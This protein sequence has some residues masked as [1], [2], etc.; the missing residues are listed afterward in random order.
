MPTTNPVPSQDPSDLL[1]NAG[2]LD[3]V[4]NGTAN[5]F[6]DRLGVA[7]RT[8]AGMN[9]DFDAQLA[10]AE[11]D[12]NVYRADAAASAAEALGYLQ[13]IRATSYG[14]YAS[15]P[16]TD[17]L[18]NPPTIGDEYFNTTA[19]LLK[20]WNGATWQASDINT[21]NLAAS[22]GSSLVGYLPAGTGAVTTTVQDRLR[23]ELRTSGYAS[24]GNAL[25]AA[26]TAGALLV[27]D[28]PVTVSANI[29]TGVPLLVVPGGQIT[30]ATGV[31]LNINGSFQAGIFRCFVCQ[32]TGK[33]AFGGSAT[34]F[35]CPEWWGAVADGSTDCRSAFTA[36]CGCGITTVQLQQGTYWFTHTASAWSSTVVVANNIIMR[37]QGK[38][39]TILADGQA[40]SS[41]YGD[42][43]FLNDDVSAEFND[44]TFQGPLTKPTTGSSNPDS[45]GLTWA[46]NYNYRVVRLNNCSVTGWFNSFLVKTSSY[47]TGYFLLEIKNCEFQSYQACVSV[48]AADDIDGHVHV[49]DSI[50]WEGSVPPTDPGFPFAHPVYIHPHI[51][52]HFER[53]RFVKWYGNKYA[54]HHYSQGGKSSIYAKYARYIDCRFEADNGG[55][56]VYGIEQSDKIKSE[57]I[58]C[59]FGPN[60]TRVVLAKPNGVVISDSEFLGAIESGVSGGDLTIDNCKIKQYALMSLS[61]GGH[62]KIS[63]SEL[64]SNPDTGIAFFKTNSNII[65]PLT[66]SLKFYNCKFIGA[67]DPLL[68]CSPIHLQGKAPVTIENCTITGQFGKVAGLRQFITMEANTKVTAHRNIFDISGSDVY[69]GLISVGVAQDDGNIQFFD[70]IYNEKCGVA[71]GFIGT[72]T[73]QY[74]ALQQKTRFTPIASAS[75]IR[76]FL[77]YD[78]YLISGTSTINNISLGDSSQKFIEGR[79]RLIATGAWST[80]STGNIIPKTTAA[81]AVNSVVELLWNPV[82]AVWVEV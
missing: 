33:V 31:T 80:S 11:S 47:G 3:E 6:T 14:A 7:R 29:S 56:Q 28:S 16:A 4:V 48:F 45:R 57:I 34:A 23:K 43:F 61:Y 39:K 78:T 62:W 1:F 27:V 55:Y 44:L 2:K 40:S 52:I 63:N 64:I 73:K 12:L 13:T 19:N 9:A 50:F 35:V 5:S 30:V 77:A 70:N 82:S 24:L 59:F 15:D 20:R 54:V 71:D 53:C 49:F 65:D 75:L 17:P 36:S 69:G 21:A 68:A 81:R 66:S 25:T 10:D 8:V 41:Y 74:I 60:I 58:R 38:G 18:G 79:I 67:A 37:G 76:I 42:M 26:T 32:G 46:N 22:S 51:N 72:P